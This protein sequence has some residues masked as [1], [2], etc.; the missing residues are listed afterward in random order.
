MFKVYFNRIQ[1]KELVTMKINIE[2]MKRISLAEYKLGLPHVEHSFLAENVNIINVELFLFNQLNKLRYLVV[3]NVICCF[4][5][6]LSSSNDTKSLKKNLL[7]LKI[8]F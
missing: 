7:I 3:Y 6:T 1:W 2:I 4:I 5:S 8:Q